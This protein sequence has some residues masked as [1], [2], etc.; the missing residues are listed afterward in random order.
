VA[1]PFLQ[2]GVTH[3]STEC[4]WSVSRHIVEETQGTVAT[5]NPTRTNSR[6]LLLAKAELVAPIRQQVA[7]HTTKHRCK[8]EARPGVVP[9]VLVSG[10][11]DV[12]GRFGRA[13][14]PVLNFI[15]YFSC[16]HRA[17]IARLLWNPSGTNP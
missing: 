13:F 4:S 10:L 9:D 15:S 3:G 17:N 7:D 14:L 2:A 11:A 1:Q 8:S 16:I 5:E 12:A 6:T